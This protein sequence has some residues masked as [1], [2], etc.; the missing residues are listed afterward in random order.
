[1]TLTKRFRVYVFAALV[2]FIALV[3]I[4]GSLQ[5]QFEP[6]TTTASAEFTLIASGLHNPRG[7]SFGPDGALYIAEAGTGGDGACIPGP[8][9]EQCYGTS[10]AVTKVLFDSE[11]NPLSQEQIVTGLSSL[12]AKGSGESATGP[13]DLGF[14]SAGDLYVLMGLG[15]DPAVRDP[16]GPFGAAGINFG[17]LVK[18]DNA[19]NWTNVLD[20][21][22]YES[23]NN[24]DGAQIDSNPYA[25]YA[26]DGGWLVVDAG[27]NDL[28]DVSV[29]SNNQRQAAPDVISTVA[30]FPARMVEF[31]PGSGQMIP[32]DAVPTAVEKG[33]DGA[34]Y[35]S[36]LTGFPFPLGGANIYRVVANEEPELYLSGFTN[37]LDLAWGPDGSLFVLEMAKDSLLADPPPMGRIIQITPYGARS[38]VASDGLIAPVDMEIGPDYALYVANFGPTADMGQVVRIH[39]PALTKMITAA[40][41]NT[42]YESDTGSLSN[43]SGQHIFAGVTDE[44][45]GNL[46]RRGLLAFDVHS[47]LPAE[48]TVL[49]ATLELNM[50]RG[51]NGDKQVSLHTVEKDWGEGASNAEGQEGAGASALNG[52]A[53]WLHTYYDTSTWNTAGGDFKTVDSASTVVG[54]VGRYNWS[55]KQLAA[56]VQDWLEGSASNFGWL[57]M[58]DESGGASAKRFD[59]RENPEADNRPKLIVRYIP[60]SPKYA[61]FAPLVN[62]SN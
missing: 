25:L 29:D 36:Q 62:T 52:D 5:A 57:L 46:I 42:L 10:G 47:S 58:G 59:S 45:T 20:I 3:A 12:G 44:G 38:V 21:S 31:P 56:D 18:V 33:P 27:G 6:A 50:S 43:G 4:L 7:L 34:Y 48:A 54:G 51:M 40:K 26:T 35:V 30:V 61:A 19:G 41:D 60:P 1:M 8:D 11:G 17:Q 28:L 24:P 15:A 39:L 13:N 16:A 22:A 2:A 53:T 23:T 32:M 37:V 55:S 14:T 9:V 49:S